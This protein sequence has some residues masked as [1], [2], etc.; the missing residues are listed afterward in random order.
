MEGQKYGALEAGDVEAQGYSV[1][2][3]AAASPA[4]PRGY[5][6]IGVAAVLGLAAVAG[7]GV[8]AWSYS[9]DAKGVTQLVEAPNTAG[10]GNGKDSPAY[11]RA[12]GGTSTGESDVGE[13]I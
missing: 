8:T 5:R 7:A 10:V 13:S 12:P 4:A 9:K 3:P 1:M 11:G 6:R 2:E